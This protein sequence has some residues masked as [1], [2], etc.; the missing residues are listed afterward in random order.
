MKHFALTIAALALS[1]SLGA[2][3]IRPEWDVHF[4]GTLVNDE[5]DASDCVLAPSGTLGALRLSPYAGIRFGRNGNHALKAGFDVM[6]DFGTAGDKPVFELAAWYQY[7]SDNGFTLAAG[8]FPFSL[9]GGFYSSLIFS[10]ASRFYDAHADGFLLRWQREKSNYE[11][12]F[13][14]CGKFD[15]NRREEFYLVSA[16]NGWVTPW[17]ALCWEGMFHHYANSEAVQGVMDDH[18]LHPFLKFEFSPVLP[19]ERLEFS[20]GGIIGYQK[21]RRTGEFYL[22]KG[23]DVVMDVRKWG[24]GIRNQFYYGQ[25]QMPFYNSQD[26]AGKVYGASL[27]YRSSWWQIRLDGGWG[28]YDR[29]EAYWMKALND[30]VE[31]GVHAVFHFDRLGYMGCQQLLQAKV[32]L[33]G[34]HFKR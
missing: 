30:W 27:Y 22:P 21:D 10:D 32:N 3:N 25:N 9:M 11:V 7:N 33:E 6:K 19:L 8:I 24:F 14:W 18:I 13:D 23:A 12:A 5:F 31:L 1:F 20:L 34:R 2:Q 28:L 17:L 29:L 16:G 26:A 15:A 4:I